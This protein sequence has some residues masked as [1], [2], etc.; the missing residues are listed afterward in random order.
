[1][2]SLPFCNDHIA[3]RSYACQHPCLGMVSLTR[4]FEA[5]GYRVAGNYSF[6]D[7]H[8]NAVHLQHTNT[9]M[10]KLFVSE[11]RTW[12]LDPTV[13]AIIHQ[14]V[15]E[16]RLEINDQHLQQLRSI[17]GLRVDTRE[18]L[19][20]QVLG[21]FQQLPWHAPDRSDLERLNQASQYAA[22]V[23]VHG[24]AVNHFTALINAHNTDSLADIDRTASA[25]R[26][27]GIPM[28][29]TIEGKV[30]SKLRQTSTTPSIVKVPVRENGQIIEIDR[31]YAY[32]E[33]AE[34]G[35]VTDPITG[36][37]CRFEGFLG[38]QATH[39][40]EMTQTPDR[41]DSPT[42]PG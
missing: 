14:L 42:T 12:E 32:F 7:K 37:L 13:A 31:P 16:A 2:R 33:L 26:S 21:L 25:L 6:D 24:F 40:F 4:I 5:L 9:A 39:L 17:E 11:L 3:F 41:S 29:S 38:S 10:P 34:R 19:M 18:P 23:S 27:A 35:N 22:W 15:A 1:M 28:K 20:N 8:L 30:G 36:N